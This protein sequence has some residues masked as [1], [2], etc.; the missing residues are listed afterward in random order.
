MLVNMPTFLYEALVAL[1][2]T[3]V[4]AFWGY[5]LHGFQRSLST[6]RRPSPHITRVPRFSIV[7]P[8]RNCVDTITTTIKSIVAQNVKPLKVV[9]VDDGSV[10]GS[11]EV[12]RA[13]AS[14]LVSRG[15]RISVVRIDSVPPG[16][17]PKPY[18][19]YQGY[20]R[21]REESEVLVFL[22]SDTWFTSEDALRALVGEAWVTGLASYAPRF[23][24]ST[25]ACRAAEVLLTTFSHAFLGFD[26]VFD[27]KSRIAWFFGCCW[28]VRKD[29]YEALGTHESVK[30][31]IVEDKALAVAAK[32]KGVGFTVL[33]GFD[34]V[35]SFWHP[36]LS[37]SVNVLTR[38][39]WGRIT[40]ERGHSLAYAAL[41]LL[42]YLA[43]ALGP[44]SLISANLF[45]VVAGCAAYGAC[46]L[47]HAIGS[48]LNG[49]SI[50]YAFAAPYVGVAMI[51]MLMSHILKGEFEWR[52][53]RADELLGNIY[54]CSA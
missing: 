27:P 33:A 37:D 30:H 20:L 36:R 12:M 43:P 18:A 15:L 34:N 38:I 44:A 8:C 22:D 5:G 47:T 24:C 11:A 7:I 54:A 28:A 32:R 21:V 9:V 45:F 42:P 2:L 10:D 14:E 4:A 49:Y 48:K 31:E 3:L 26:K 17:L 29:V 6:L 35:A 52:G 51:C 41:F 50:A 23:V 1:I 13:L 39:F 19:C 25:R 16:W 46:V 53:R 40:R